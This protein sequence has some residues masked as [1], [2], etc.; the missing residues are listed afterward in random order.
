MKNLYTAFLCIFFLL[1]GLT[2][3]HANSFSSI[4]GNTIGSDQT[5]CNNTT[6]VALTGTIPGGGTGVYAYQWQVSTTSA[7]AGFANIGGGTAQGYAPGVLVA[8]RWYRRIVTSGI[9]KDTT[10]AVTITVTPVITPASNVITGV[11]TICYNTIPATITGPTATGGNGVYAYQWQSS[12]DNITFSNIPGANG[13]TYTPPAIIAN[14]WYKRIVSSGGCTNTSASVQVTVTPLITVGTNTITADQS[15]CNGQIPLTLNGSTP[16]G[17]NGAFTYLWESSTTSAVAGFTTAAGVSNGKNYT[18]PAALTQTTWYHR[19]VISGGCNDISSS[20]QITVVN[21]PPGNPAVFGN[22]VWNVYGYSDNAFGTYA[23]FYTEPVLSFNTVSRY[24]NNQSPSSA[25]GYQ[26]CLIPASNFSASMKQT[27]FTP[28]NYQL[29]LNSLDDNLTVILNGTQIYTHGCCVAAPINNIWTGALGASDQIELRWVGL[30]SPNYLSMA[31]VPVTPAP[32][33]PG[34]ISQDMQVCYGEVP[35][36]GFTSTAAPTSGCSTIA[37]QW[38]KSIDNITWVPIV[39]ATGLIY[40]ESAALIQTTW[41]R[42]VATD[43]CNNSAATTPVKVTVNVVAPGDPT[44]YGNNTWNVYV[45]QGTGAPG[46]YNAATYK[47]Y[48]TEPLLSFDSKNRWNQN[49]SPSTASGYQG[50]IVNP[51]N[52]WIDYKRTNFTP[53]V[54]QIDIPY[55]D[56]DAYLFINGVQVFVHNGCCDAHTNVWTGPLGATDQVEFRVSQGGGPSS[57][58]LTLTPVT[59]PV[60]TSGAITPDQ[61]ICAG[62]VP[63]TPLTEITAPTGGCTIKNYTWEYSTDNGTTW[64]LISGANAI[65]YTIATSIYTQTLY[66]RTVNDVCGNSAVSAPITISMNNSAPGNPAVFGNNVW[67]VYCFQDVSYSIYAGYYTEPLLTFSTP[68]RY[69]ATSPPSTAS[70]YLG[71]QLINTFYSV[72]MKRT[73]F[74]AG[75]YQIDVTSD[76]DFNSIY[77]N[78]VLVS[79]LTFPTIQN[80]VWTGNLGP[81]DQIEVRWRNNNGPGQTG[82]RFTLVTATP[83]VPGSIVAY[84]PNLCFNDLPII[85][86]VTPASGGCFV[87]YSWQSSIDGGTTWT[88]IAGATGNSFTATVSPTTNIQY[89]RVATDVCGT[90]AYSAPVSFIQAAGTVGNPAV[91]GNG[92]WNVYAYNA[93]AGVT[94]FSAAQYLGYYTEP[95]LSFDSRTRWNTATGSPSDASGYQGCQVDQDNHWVAYK[96]TNFTSGTYQLDVA[97][98]DDDGYLFINGVLV[99]SHIGCCDVH[100][101][102]W[103]G[104]L[105]PTDQIEF[106]WRDYFGGSLGALNFTL[107]TPATAVVPG[108]IAADQVI[109]SNTIPVAFTSTLDASSSCFVYYQW[110]SSPDNATWSDISGATSNVYAS[111]AIA[112]KTYFRRKAMNACSVTAYSNTVTVDVYPVAL[113]AGVI[114]ADQTFCKGTTAA[115]LNSTSLP[116]GG[117]GVYTYQWQSSLDNIGWSNI[118]LATLTTYAPGAPVVT[119]YFRRVAS[120]CGTTST[121]Y[122]NVVTLTVNQVPTITTQPNTPSACTGGSTTITVAATGTGLTYQW[123]EK[124]G[125]GPFTNLT[126][127]APYSGVNTPTLTLNPVTAG[128]AGNKYQV[129]I[130]SPTCV[131]AVT[132]NTVIL[133]VA[134]NPSIT[135]QPASKSF[136]EGTNATVS[137]VASGTGLTYQWQ[138]QIGGVWTNLV[139]DATYNGTLTSV[140]T[141]NNVLLAMNSDKNYRVLLGS[142]CAG[143]LTSNTAAITVVA[144][145]VNTISADQTFCTGIAP[146]PLNGSAASTYQWQSSTVSPVSGFVNASGASTGIGYTPPV[147]STTTYYQ[148]IAGNGTCTSTSNVVTMTLNNATITITGQPANQDICA[149]GTATFT[150]TATGPGTL[151]YQWYENVTPIVDG[152][153]YSGST[154]NTLTL[155]GATAGMNNNTYTLRVFA[156]GCSASFKNSAAAT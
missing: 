92:I 133:A 13:T 124:V 88:T 38:Q 30:N 91:F 144:A 126:N 21:A 68:N 17:G 66:R 62:N 75:L 156:S 79:S 29:N 87:N 143:S 71:C 52:T 15:V 14:T 80:N 147:L 63:P 53:A 111:G 134:V 51:N 76:D 114:S 49:A 86:E 152:G 34:S 150:G 82:V 6:P 153:I 35:P 67:N 127:V 9:E 69:P 120:S 105:G 54:Y 99:W 59:P 89:R 145:L 151:S 73:G 27:N 8:N 60:L 94:P 116:T 108:T 39:G 130:T 83:L 148:R 56:D 64:N 32:L 23:G 137:I 37:M 131:P 77:I 20:V 98:H 11:Q 65:S 93:P 18:P 106:R 117:N 123:Q 113:T 90:V 149:G 102:V 141:I 16:T 46:P 7:I 78:G 61:T 1:S 33:V 135:T 139:D 146:A 31:F 41:Y 154:T 129:I 26:G 42:R 155:T 132:S 55:H 109:C 121:A 40:T 110:Q 100:N 57:E 5:I 119:T 118:N 45:F 81:T 28:G 122:S 103:T 107:V 128:M 140:L 96:R 74:T 84:N 19:I 58:I 97:G 115:T 44:V 50:C 3:S 36:S 43:A 70:G 125:P 24:T 104:V 10:S 2:Q 12:P 85:N 136:C 25:S 112:A 142:S 95:L 47:G 22:G 48:Y 72:S 138:R 4:T 101:N